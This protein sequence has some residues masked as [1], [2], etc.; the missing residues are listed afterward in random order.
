MEFPS[1]SARIY[2]N[3]LLQQIRGAF[4]RF[5][6]AQTARRAQQNVFYLASTYPT[7]NG[8][9]GDTMGQRAFTLVVSG[10][11]LIGVWSVTAQDNAKQQAI[12]DAVAEGAE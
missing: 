11:I 6:S 9:G 1:I 2:S 4:W 8:S 10:L 3:L 12:H 5:Q 7:K